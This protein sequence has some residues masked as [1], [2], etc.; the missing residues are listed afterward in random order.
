MILLDRYFT[1]RIDRALDEGRPLSGW[2]ARYVRNRPELREY[3]ESML[4]MELEL[5][6]P[7]SEVSA[8]ETKPVAARPG[9]GDRTKKFLLQGVAPIAVLLALV[10]IPLIPLTMR[11]GKPVEP[12]VV[13]KDE[14][15]DLADLLGIAAPLTEIVPTPENPLADVQWGAWSNPESILPVESVVR[16]TEQPLESLVSLLETA[17]VVHERPVP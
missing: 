2:T 15:I 5:R 17:R 1:A 14:R 10:L 12:V 4:E 13:Q 6:F 7:L 11:P 16:F 3:Y 9:V 8:T